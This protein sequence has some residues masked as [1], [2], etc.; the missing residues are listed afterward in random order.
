V[1]GACVRP[2]LPGWRAGPL[3]LAALAPGPWRHSSRLPGPAAAQCSAARAAGHP[4]AHGLHHDGGRRVAV[5]AQPHAVDRVEAQGEEQAS[6]GV[7]GA[8]DPVSVGRLAGCRAAA[9][10]LAGCCAAAG[11]LPAG[12]L[13]LAGCWLTRARASSLPGRAPPPPAGPTTAAPVCRYPSP[14]PAPTHP[15]PNSG[16]PVRPCK[17]ERSAAAGAPTQAGER[18]QRVERVLLPGRLGAGGDL[19]L[20]LLALIL[21]LVACSSSSSS[22]RAAPGAVSPHAC[23]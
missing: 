9:G 22:S 8:R 15:G 14:R 18:H 7:G 11:Q 10:R 6:C 1:G 19:L 23:H 12:T 4:P 13:L 16:A 3:L 17:H 2:G 5:G 20:L 21:P